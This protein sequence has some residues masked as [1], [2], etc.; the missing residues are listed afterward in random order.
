M[1]DENSTTHPRPED[2]SGD[3][4]VLG[5]S[6]ALDAMKMVFER[7]LANRSPFGFRKARY[8]NEFHPL[9]YRPEPGDRLLLEE[10]WRI[11]LELYEG[12]QPMVMGLD[13]YGDAILGRG[14]SRPG[15]IILNLEEY[16]AQEH[17]VSREHA[18]LRPTV[19]RLFLIDQGSTNGTTLNGTPSGRGM[20]SPVN[21]EDMIALGN[22]LLLVRVVKRPGDWQPGELEQAPRKR[23]TQNSKTD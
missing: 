3:T 11:V 14:P 17:G 19:N 1:T 13:L 23:P 18:M 6:A 8:P 2:E 10:P 22:L 20:A 7:F 9:P 16:G 5:G 21:D 4:F 12:E 15:R